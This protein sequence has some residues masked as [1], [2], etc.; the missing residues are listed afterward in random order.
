VLRACLAPG[1]AAENPA[2]GANITALIAQTGACGH[3]SALLLGD[4]ILCSRGDARK[5]RQPLCNRCHER[6]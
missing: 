2:D 1:A 3:M 5:G 4:P 6:V